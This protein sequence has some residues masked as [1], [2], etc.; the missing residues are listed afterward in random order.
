[1]FKTIKNCP[2]C[3]STQKTEIIKNNKNIYSYFSFKN[4]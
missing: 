1:M 3:G 4:S 2:V